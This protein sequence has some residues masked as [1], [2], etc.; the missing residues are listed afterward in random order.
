VI[1][2][3]SGGQ[4]RSLHLHLAFGILHSHVAPLLHRRLPVHVHGHRSRRA[5]RSRGGPR[6]CSIARPSIPPPAGSRSTRAFLERRSRSSTSS[7]S[8]TAAWRTS[9]QRP[10]SPGTAVEGRVDWARRFDHMQQHTGQH[11]LSAAFERLHQ[12][13]TISFHLGSA[14]STIDFVGADR[15]RMPSPP[16]NREANRIVWEDRP[17][18]VR[19]VSAP[20]TRRG[21][22]SGRNRRARAR[23]ASSR[24][25]TTTS[26]PAAGRTW[27]ERARSASS[28]SPA[29]S[30]SRAARAWSS[31]AAAGRWPASARCARP[32]PAPC[33]CSPC[34][35]TSCRLPSSDSRPSSRRSGRP[36]RRFRSGSHPTTRPRSQIGR[37][38]RLVPRRPGGRRRSGRGLAQGRSQ[39]PSRP[40]TRTSPCSSATAARCRSSSP[41]A[42]ACRRRGR[43]PAR[44]HGPKFG[45]KG[46]GR[47]EMAQGGFRVRPDDV[48]AAGARI[49]AF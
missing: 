23:C 49:R 2:K 21:C 47:P 22:R 4:T 5:R 15:A 36:S 42:A 6:S 18:T 1:V 34:C 31:S 16:P 44:A 10:L 43:T 40:V 24:S 41:A 30:A 26:P 14:G 8:R 33:G 12:A 27:R 20:R 32:W 13:R 9:S 11:V 45:G 17:V 46:G 25:T 48:L 38:G 3:S 19:F 28:P 37:K 39:P 7:N 35:R 29:S